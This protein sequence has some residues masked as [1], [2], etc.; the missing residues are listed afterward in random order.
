MPRKKPARYV[1]IDTGYGCQS[2]YETC[3]VLDERRCKGLFSDELQTDLL[4]ELAGGERIWVS[5]WEE[6]PQKNA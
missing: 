5:S 6:I 2:I 1:K 3:K 4:V